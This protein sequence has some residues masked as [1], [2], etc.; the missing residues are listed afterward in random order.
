MNRLYNFLEILFYRFNRI[1]LRGQSE[2]DNTMFSL[3]VFSLFID[4]NFLSMLILI[5]T[6]CAKRL[7]PE[8]EKYIII[9]LFIISIIIN[10]FLFVRKKKY[11]LIR[12]KYSKISMKHKKNINFLYYTYI[13]LT[14]LIVF[15]FLIFFSGHQIN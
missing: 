13:V 4:L 12:E 15:V 5:E 11:L 9:S 8:I 2:E 1:K 10:Y 7:G 14:I 3:I 6:I